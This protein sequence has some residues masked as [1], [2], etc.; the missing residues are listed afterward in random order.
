MTAHHVTSVQAPPEGTYRIDPERSRVAYSGRHMFGLGR[1]HATFA[2]SSGTLQV[3]EP[4]TG[5]RVEVTV[6]AASFRSNSAKRDKDVRSASLL[7]A[8]AHPD[9][10]FCSQALRRDG[11]S[12]RVTGIATAHGTTVTVEVVVDQ[13][14]PQAGGVHVHA[15]ADHLDRYAFDVTNAKGMVGRYLDLD[16]D[17][18]AVPA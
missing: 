14:T 3:A 6:D 13:V 18:F 7:D 10:T 4:F 2:V 9:I 15:R 1:V 11:D 17:V 12:W 8:E 5:S 16:L